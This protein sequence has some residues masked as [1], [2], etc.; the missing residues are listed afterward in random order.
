MY[1]DSFTGTPEQIRAHITSLKL[2]GDLPEHE[3]IRTF[4]LANVPKYGVGKWQYMVTADC[5]DNMSGDRMAAFLSVAA[6][7]VKP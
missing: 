7:E 4:M 6:C 3:A 2:P 1:R 5:A